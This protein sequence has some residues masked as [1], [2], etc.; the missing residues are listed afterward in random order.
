MVA[1]RALHMFLKVLGN[2]L[3]NGGGKRGEERQPRMRWSG[4]GRGSCVRGLLP[5][6]HVARGGLIV[7]LCAPAT[8]ALGGSMGGYTRIAA[9]YG[10]V[11]V[12]EKA[13]SRKGWMVA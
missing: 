8:F 4:G 5:S 11:W 7:R 1:T 12:V 13:K 9:C 10:Y 3:G 2:Y 6:L